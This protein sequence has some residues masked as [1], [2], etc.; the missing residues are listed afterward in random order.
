M[1]LQ[2]KRH[3]QKINYKLCIKCQSSKKLKELPQS[4]EHST[5]DKFLKAVHWRASIG[6]NDFITLSEKL[7]GSTASDLSDN[8][9][10]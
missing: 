7:K 9:V 6:N 1:N 2:R 4:E 3:A 10:V 5:Y 8:H